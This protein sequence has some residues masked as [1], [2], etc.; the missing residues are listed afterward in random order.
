MGR[1]TE[2]SLAGV[3]AC[4]RAC[5]RQTDA[6]ETKEAHKLT[7]TGDLMSSPVQMSVWIPHG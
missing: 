5:N 6:K 2:A 3:R 7:Q 4:L 1:D